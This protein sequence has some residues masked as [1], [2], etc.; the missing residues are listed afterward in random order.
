[1]L[2]VKEKGT[3]AS[4]TADYKK[5]EKREYK[6]ACQNWVRGH[7]Q[8]LQSRGSKIVR[9]YMKKGGGGL[10]KGVP[11]Q[12][13]TRKKIGQIKWGKEVNWDDGGGV[14][15]NSFVGGKRKIKGGGINSIRQRTIKESVIV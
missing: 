3:H 9:D 14:Q 4:K 11:L 2:R 7:P 15:G 1:M 5:K 10:W 8:P 12:V 6:T 13:S